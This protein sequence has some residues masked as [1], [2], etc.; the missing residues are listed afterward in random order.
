MLKV[1]TEK[2]EQQAFYEALEKSRG[3]WICGYCASIGTYEQLKKGYIY[4]E[5]SR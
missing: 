2:E 1:Y 5:N 3:E 4:C